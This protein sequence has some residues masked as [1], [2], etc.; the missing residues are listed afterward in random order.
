M[1]APS[2]SP[3][4]ATPCRRPAARLARWALGL[5]LAPT[6]AAEAPPP[7]AHHHHEDSG[8]HVM[9]SEAALLGA[10]LPRSPAVAA[11]EAELAARRQGERAADTRPDPML[12]LGVQ[13]LPAQTLRL[14]D[15]DMGGLMVGLAQ[16]IEPWGSLDARRRL[17]AAQSG[18][19]AA[20]L[21][22]ELTLEARGLRRDYWLALS[23]A[24]EARHL[25][26]ERAQ[27]A[28]L[29]PLVE[30]R[31]AAGAEPATSLPA[32][33]LAI[34]GLNN[35]AAALEAEAAAAAAP[36]AARF[37]AP[38]RL[39][40]PEELPRR[41]APRPAP[42]CAA[43]ALIDP[44]IDVLDAM[45]EQEQAEA[46]AARLGARPGLQVSAGLMRRVQPAAGAS[47]APMSP[48]L[49]TVGAALPLPFGAARRAEAEAG[50]ALSRA[51]AAAASR[52]ARVEAACGLIHGGLLRWAEAEARAGRLEGEQLPAAQAL[53]DLSWARYRSGDAPLEAPLRAAAERHGLERALHAARLEAI[54][55]HIDL[56]GAEPGG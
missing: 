18:A 7:E 49:I 9:E 42:G 2:P 5:G 22:L 4:G 15:E 11:A 40:A 14:R 16:P 29:L 51:A 44:M 30:A 27:L 36:L 45:Y 6:A 3:A 35:E 54:L 48:T 32:L 17:A 28:E 52:R 55:W 47:H 53:E 20:A 33:R 38:L 1:H 13:N 21:D 34:A 46:A 39:R 50:A 43:P 31:Y 37:G 41:P 25:R 19:A 24:I 10:L 56:A 26:E 8:A 12:E 23:P